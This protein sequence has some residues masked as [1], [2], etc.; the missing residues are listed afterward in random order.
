MTPGTPTP[1]ASPPDPDAVTGKSGDPVSPAREPC[2]EVQTDLS[3]SKPYVRPAA[4][5][6]HLTVDDNQG[7][8]RKAAKVGY[9]VGLLAGGWWGLGP[10]APAMLWKNP[11]VSDLVGG[12]ISVVF[13]APIA[14]IL[15]GGLFWQVAL[16]LQAICL[17]FK[18][19]RDPDVQ[20]MLRNLE[21][22]DEDD[23]EDEMSPESEARH[24]WTDPGIQPEEDNV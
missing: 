1:D 4:K 19:A 14:S 7:F 8:P 22:T 17:S 15:F 23:S 16:V 2:P 13:A 10:M 12:F 3:P 24:P 18:N 20:K 5:R 9:I 21:E 11:S 6:A